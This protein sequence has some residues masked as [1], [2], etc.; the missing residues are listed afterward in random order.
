MKVV[1]E[2]QEARD[3]WG[4][5]HGSADQLLDFERIMANTRKDDVAVHV[6]DPLGN[7]VTPHPLGVILPT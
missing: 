6:R 2:E 4:N 3:P 7:I 1:E 5:S